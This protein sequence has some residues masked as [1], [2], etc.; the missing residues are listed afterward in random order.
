MCLPRWCRWWCWGGEVYCPNAASAWKSIKY[1]DTLYLVY[2]Y[3]VLQFMC[4][5]CL[6]SKYKVYRYSILS[7]PIL[8]T[9]YTYTLYLVYRY[10]ILGIPILYLVYR[11]FIFRILTLARVIFGR[12]VIFSFNLNNYYIEV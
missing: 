2:R 8:H 10:S 6:K 11:Y 5:Y 1:T 3:S 9:W 4:I 12:V 7:I